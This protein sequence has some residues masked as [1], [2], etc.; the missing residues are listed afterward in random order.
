M[1]GS[2]PTQAPTVSAVEAL[3]NVVLVG[4]SGAGKSRLFDHIVGTLT[5][6]GGAGRAPGERSPGLRAATLENGGRSSPSS[7]HRATPTSWA[8]SGLG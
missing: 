7:M 2:S 1:T 6:G 3:R 5:G 8:R 4:P